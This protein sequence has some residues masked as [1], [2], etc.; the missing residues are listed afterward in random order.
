MNTLSVVIERGV[1]SLIRRWKDKNGKEKRKYLIRFGREKPVFYKPFIFRGCVED[2]IRDIKDKS[3]N[4]ILTD[5]PYGVTQNQWDI[6]PDWNWL[7]NECN[8]VLVDNGLIA[9]FG[10]YPMLYDVVKSFSKVFDFRYEVIWDKGRG[11]MWT[12]DYIPMLAHEKVLVF[13]KKDCDVTDTIFN[14]KE[15]GMMKNPYEMKKRSLSS[16]Y[17]FDELNKQVSITTKS[18]G[19]RFPLSIIH[20]PSIQGGHKEYC[21]FPTQKPERVIEWFIRG[22]TNRHDFVFDP[23][24]G[25]GTVCKVSMLLQRQSM[26]SEINPNALKIVKNRLCDI[27]KIKKKI[28]WRVHKNIFKKKI[29]NFGDET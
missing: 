23:Y 14:Y 7:A 13:K 28:D 8:R 29:Y 16:N 1:Y 10:T 22:L 27:Y 12:S 24:L 15:I 9:I 5:P 19:I 11:G 21:G 26:G 3:I 2:L 4:L 18:D 20:E 6:L 25:S 17:G